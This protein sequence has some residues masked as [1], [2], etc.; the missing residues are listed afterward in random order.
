MKILNVAV[1]VLAV[2][3]E[4]A[5]AAYAALTGEAVSA[6]FAVPGNGVEVATLGAIT[7]IAGSKDLLAPF[8]KIR[9]TFTVDSLDD[10]EAHLRASG[11]SLLQPPSQTPSGRTMIARLSDSTVFEFVELSEEG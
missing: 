1:P 2:N 8:E 9:A 5:I 7:I 3:M 10:Y 11:A 6:R 4:V